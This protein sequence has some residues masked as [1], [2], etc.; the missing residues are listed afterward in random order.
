[1][2][3]FKVDDHL[4]TH[5]K[6]AAAGLAPMG[7]W[8]KAG[9]WSAQQLTDG[10][11]PT[12]ILN[13]LGARRSH[14]EALVKAGLWS[15]EPEGYRFRDWFDYQPTAEKSAD[16]KE[17]RRE[18]GRRGGIASGQSRAKGNQT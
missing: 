9:A 3:W 13:L 4:A 7:L 14:A 5:A 6:V 16:V 1:M 17:K 8:V 18:A 12:S 10:F 15:V 11:I 2:P